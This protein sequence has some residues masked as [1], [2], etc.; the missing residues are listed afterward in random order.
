MSRILQSTKK[1]ILPG[2]D[3][4]K[5]HG[6]TTIELTSVVD[7]SKKIIEH[8]NVFQNAVLAKFMRSLGY[9]NN[10]PYANSTWKD[11]AAWRNLVGGI[12]LF[13]DSIDLS[14]G[15]V[16]FMPAGNA[17][18]ANGSYG[19]TNS[20]NPIELGSYNSV[21][22]VIGDNSLTF[23]YDWDTSHGNGTISTVC[24][25]SETGG[26]IGY[27]NPSGTSGSTRLLS[28]NQSD[29]PFSTG[30]SQMLSQMY[31]N[32]VFKTAVIDT[33]E[34][35]VTVNYQYVPVDKMS[36]F[37]RQDEQLI[38]YYS[39]SLPSTPDQ[40][41]N[42]YTKLAVDG[43]YLYL[44]PAYNGEGRTNLGNGGTY[45]Y[46]K[47]DL[48][49]KT[50]SLGT[51][52]N[53]T[54]HT[55]YVGTSKQVVADGVIYCAASIQGSSAVDASIDLIRLSDSSYI[56]SLTTEQRYAYTDFL[57]VFAD[58]LIQ[59]GRADGRSWIYDTVNKTL[60]PTNGHR[61]IYQTE[62]QSATLTNTN[63][64][65]DGLL[66]CFYTYYRTDAHLFKNPLYLATVNN[67][68]SPVVKSSTQTMKVT[69]TL[70]E[71]S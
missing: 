42:Y 45:I 40:S 36:I 61:S 68:E 23:V 15:D 2:E 35:K 60:L 29:Q 20:G 70:T 24:L 14:G 47:I 69:Y 8:D 50:A 4:G 13:R 27:G 67:L 64:A 44:F 11:N 63:Q 28:D 43:D 9:Y 3:M 37:A 5:I 54:G 17:M 65:K 53:N 21:E 22:S 30:N 16:A 34:N 52:T 10:N 55:I 71:A 33:S 51:F 46:I 38:V 62:Y 48:V 18:T 39:G 26:Y 58:G 1:F 25:T 7:G 56:D 59:S 66:S 6:H 12:F 32:Y 31:K 49:A 41:A 57:G 19:V